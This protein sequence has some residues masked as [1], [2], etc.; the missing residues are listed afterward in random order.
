[1]QWRKNGNHGAGKRK[2]EQNMNESVLN[3]EKRLLFFMET[4]F[5]CRFHKNEWKISNFWVS[6]WRKRKKLVCSPEKSVLGKWL[7]VMTEC[8]KK[9][10]S[11]DE[12][13]GAHGKPY[14][15]STD[16]DV[17]DVIGILPN[18]S[19]RGKRARCGDVVQALAAKGQPILIVSV[20]AKLRVQITGEIF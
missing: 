11:Q 16:S 12:E 6:I 15:I 19:V 20:G 17:P 1:M 13:G 7:P 10:S 18:G 4:G 5:L 9:P 3:R 8:Q 14:G 2:Y